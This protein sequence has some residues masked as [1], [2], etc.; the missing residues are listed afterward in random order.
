MEYLPKTTGFVLL[1]P[2]NT[3]QQERMPIESIEQ[4][5]TWIAVRPPGF[6]SAP[7]SVIS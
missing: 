2:A 4:D 5:T 3:D 6:R 7:L 1:E